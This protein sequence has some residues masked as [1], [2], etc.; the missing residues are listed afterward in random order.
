MKNFA[1]VLLA[2]ACLF[3]CGQAKADITQT[4]L[5]AA[6]AVKSAVQ[7]IWEATRNTSPEGYLHGQVRDLGD[8]LGD[9]GVRIYQLNQPQGTIDQLNNQLYSLSE[10]HMFV[11][12]DLSTV[13]TAASNLFNS[14]N[15]AYEAWIANPTEFVQLDVD[16]ELAGYSAAMSDLS[17]DYDEILE[18]IGDLQGG[19]LAL[20]T[21]V[22]ELE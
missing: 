18:D 9:L 15:E 14:V 1:S 20:M 19:V 8:D 2:V 4:T 6:Y 16:T 10:T 21:T 3:N 11:S 22:G 13:G 7:A 5:D 12:S 17:D